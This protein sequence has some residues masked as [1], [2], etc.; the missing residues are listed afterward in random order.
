MEVRFCMQHLLSD[1]WLCSTTG[2]LADKIQKVRVNPENGMR[3][4]NAAPWRG[5]RPP[6]VLGLM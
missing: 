4:I 2:S 6:K 3:S 1:A 5:M